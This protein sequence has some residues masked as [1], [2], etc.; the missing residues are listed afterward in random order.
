MTPTHSQAEPLVVERTFDAPV[1]LVWKAITNRDDICK[2]SFEMKEFKA[3][4][5]FE[6]EFYGGK[7]DRQFLHK[8]RVTEVT[9]QKRL[10]YTWRYDGYEG[11]SLVTID[12]VAIGN[13][14]RLKLTHSGIETFPAIPDFARENFVAGWTEIIGSLLKNH[15]ENATRDAGAPPFVIS[16]EFSAPRDVVWKAWTER[17]H[18]MQWF[19]PKGFTMTT[20]KLDFRVG[21]IFHYCMSTPDGKEMWGKFVYR[22]IVRPEKIVWV[23]SFSDKDG[24][25]TRHPF[26][27]M[28]WPLQM[29][30]EAKFTELNGRTNVTIT[31]KAIEATDEERQ[32]FDGMHGSMTQGWTG[33]FER[34]AAQLAK[35]S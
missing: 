16:R 28:V 5:G 9:P 25:V 11:D 31:S 10:A 17:E 23:N 3:Q 27:N 22:E 6:F 1:A 19:G 29:L 18:L 32:T 30:T 21:G 33:T 8:C 14:T 2:W 15:V 24:G 35:M 34:L 20:A 26:S 4:V 12:L 13:K 7:D